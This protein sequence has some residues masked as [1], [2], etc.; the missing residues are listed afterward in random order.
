LINGLREGHLWR[1]RCRSSRGIIGA[2]IATVD[3]DDIHAMDQSQS[4]R[5]RSYLKYFLLIVGKV[6]SWR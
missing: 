6:Y 4:R 3:R 5:C 2:I 1:R